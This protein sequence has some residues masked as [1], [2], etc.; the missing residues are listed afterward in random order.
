MKFTKPQSLLLDLARGISAQLVLVGHVMSAEKLENPK[1]LF[2][3]LG[4]A[5]F[6][7]LSGL[8]VTHSVLNKPKEYSFRD[9]FI[10]RGARIFVPCTGGRP[11]RG[12]QYGTS[13][14]RSHRY[15]HRHSKPPVD[16]RLSAL[17]VLLMVP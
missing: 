7:I 12:L 2:Q 4:V 13:S 15:F 9:Y 11:Y 6:F 17:P 16:G 5:T 14:R 8:L 10:D 3:N 1:L